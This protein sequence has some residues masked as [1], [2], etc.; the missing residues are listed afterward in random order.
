MHGLLDERLQP[1]SGPSTQ[2]CHR[3]YT[4]KLLKTAAREHVRQRYVCPKVVTTPGEEKSDE[5]F[6]VSSL[7][8]HVCD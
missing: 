1:V 6:D 2:S 7:V 8:F 5:V 4:P 3:N